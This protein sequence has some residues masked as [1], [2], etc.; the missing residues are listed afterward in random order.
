MSDLD[1]ADLDPS[2]DRSDERSTVGRREEVR[3]PL[4]KGFDPAKHQGFLLQKLSERRG[5]GWTIDLI[6]MR[7]SVAFASRTLTLTQVEA[8]TKT[9]K[10]VT[11]QTNVKPSD[12]DRLAAQFADQFPGFQMTE[13]EPHIG[14]ARLTKMSASEAHARG[15]VAEIMRVKP[16]QVT[17]SARV[18]GGFNVILPA[19]YLPSKHDG[20]LNEVAETVIGEPGWYAKFDGRTRK[21]ALVPGTLPTFPPTVPHPL[22]RSIKAEVHT[23]F[24]PACGHWGRIP[25]GVLLAEPGGPDGQLLRTDF[26]TNPAMQISGIAGSGKGQLIMS[27][28]TGALAHGWQVG[29]VDAVKA[30]VDYVDLK[31]FL[32][33][34]FCA[35]DVAQAVCVLQ[36]AYDE[37]QRRKKLIKKHQVQKFTQLPAL[38]GM[39]PLMIIVDEATSLLQAEP[40]PKGLPKDSALL[41]EIG[42]RNMLKATALNLMSKIPRELRFAGVSL[43][44]AS[45]VASTTVGIP[46]ELRSNLPAKVLLGP[47]PTENNRRLALANHDMVPTVPGY[48]VDDARGA[49][50]GVGVFEF[51]GKTP[52]VFKGFFNQPGDLASWLTSLAL[53]RTLDPTPTETHLSRHLPSLARADDRDRDR[54]P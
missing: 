20:K 21:G 49:A 28:I 17:V 12:G 1:V 18:G 8:V 37:G 30:C 13:F 45:Q 14:R 43:V 29:L 24:D 46:T 6:D 5:D 19:S 27:L 38:E 35:E 4:P 22:G 15:A 3:I 26:E 44:V 23:R 32:R 51:E 48:I 36:M 50:R 40:T 53:P 31:P 16:W 10:L 34:G 25:L 9:T 11:L 42:E 41:Y 52:G 7:E 2:A 54:E 47:K 33:P 39:R